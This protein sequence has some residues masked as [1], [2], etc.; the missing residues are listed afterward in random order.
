MEFSLKI[1]IVSLY[2]IHPI[3]S[4]GVSHY[5]MKRI[6]IALFTAS[7]C[8]MLSLSAFAEGNGTNGPSPQD[9]PP[10]PPQAF[11]TDGNNGEPPVDSGISPCEINEKNDNF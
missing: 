7:L 11:E 9:P 2:V 3:T 8:F 6:V 5:E 10:A 1:T 4:K